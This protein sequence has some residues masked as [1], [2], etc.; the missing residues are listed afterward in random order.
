[1]PGTSSNPSFE[2]DR[3]LNR[4]RYK[5]TKRLVSRYKMLQLT[6][7]FRLSLDRQSDTLVEKLLSGSITPKQ[8][9]QQFAYQV[10]LQHVQ[11]LILGRG[12][13]D[14]VT[15]EDYLALARELKNVH[16]P[17]LVVFVKQYEAQ[18]LTPGQVKARA[19]LYSRATRSSLEYGK[20]EGL[21]EAGVE[22]AFRQLAN[23]L[24]CPDCL[25]YAARG[26]KPIKEL[27]LPGQNCACGGNC[28]C[29]LVPVPPDKPKKSPKKKRPKRDAT[30]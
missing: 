7:D 14:K 16:Y 8:F 25:R 12:G 4:Y 21:I 1:M 13:K 17:R 22:L 29:S 20:R 10:K 6:Q 26:V 30:L 2:Y 18:L 5:D 28:R 24:H 19:R 11:A 3:K 9:K 23:C 15:V 27:P